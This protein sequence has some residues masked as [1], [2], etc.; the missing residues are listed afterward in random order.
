MPDSFDIEFHAIFRR[1]SR[2]VDFRRAYGSDAVRERINQAIYALEGKR[3][4]MEERGQ[5]P[6]KYLSSDQV[7]LD[8]LLKNNRFPDR[9]TDELLSNPY[10]F[11]ALTVRY[12]RKKAVQL[13]LR[14]THRRTGRRPR[15][16]Y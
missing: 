9:L 5:H 8:K 11:P 3:T 7:Q 4:I 2:I 12:G 14:K 1:V 10:G 16:R 15:R 13:S 6:P